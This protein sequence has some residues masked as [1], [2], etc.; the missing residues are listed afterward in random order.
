MNIIVLSIL[1][2][3]LQSQLSTSSPAQTVNELMYFHFAPRG[4]ANTSILES[5]LA[6][7]IERGL[8]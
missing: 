7:V 8:N 1:N 4:A 5:I 6:G 2:V 3:E